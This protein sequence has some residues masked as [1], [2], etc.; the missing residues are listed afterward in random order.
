MKDK[1]KILTAITVAAILVLALASLVIF[2]KK[3]GKNLVSWGSKNKNIS[4]SSQNASEE[5]SAEKVPQTISQDSVLPS[6]LP[7]GVSSG[8]LQSVTGKQGGATV[9]AV[10]DGNNF[11]L[12]LEAKLPDAP[13]GQNYT[14]WLANDSS[15]AD[16]TMLGKLEKKDHLYILSFNKAG[17]FSAY[18]IVIVTLETKDD[19]SPEARVLEGKI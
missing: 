16:L 10:A 15:S 19:N 11:S 5:Q 12:V 6:N 9:F 8:N 2:N 18:K 4:S 3:G 7:P 1:R 13:V 14:A 17:D